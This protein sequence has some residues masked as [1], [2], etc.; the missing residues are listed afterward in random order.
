MNPKHPTDKPYAFKDILDAARTYF[1]NTQFY[2]PAHHRFRS[3]HDNGDNLYHDHSTPDYRI[4]Q[5]SD[6]QDTCHHVI[7]R[8]GHNQDTDRRPNQEFK[9]G[10]SMDQSSKP[11]QEDEDKV[12][13]DII[14]GMVGL[15]TRDSAYTVLYAKC[16]HHFPEIAKSLPTPE[17]FRSTT[18]VTYQAPTMQQQA[19]M[20][21]P[22]RAPI[23]GRQ[24]WPQPEVQFIDP[25]MEG[26]FFCEM[27]TD[28]C[29]FCAKPGHRVCGCPAAQE[30]IC[31]GHAI[32]KNDRICLPTGHPIPNDGSRRGLKHGI[33]TWL[34]A[35]SATTGELSAT[36]SQPQI[37]TALQR[38]PLPHIAL[39]LEIVP[40]NRD[41]E[42]SDDSSNEEIYNMYE[43]LAAEQKKHDTRPSKLPEATPQ[44][45]ATTSIAAPVTHP[46]GISNA[47]SMQYQF[48]SGAEDQKLTD[49][50]CSWLLAGKLMQTTPAHILAAS[51]PI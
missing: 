1:V 35:S 45:I 28:G 40:D 30:Y 34:A 16:K 27:R 17:L 43:V 24:P 8:R 47:Q 9:A 41:D 50:L 48:Q 31:T 4:R 3:S 19:A 7:D 23:A 42:E 25:D 13:S 12:L 33:D 22:E 44:S 6:D 37:T 10:W 2:Q 18:A 26:A 32:I 29:A 14:T 38:D 11:V 20:Q 49:E 39:A 5:Q 15:S 36:I 21:L 51:A 46:P